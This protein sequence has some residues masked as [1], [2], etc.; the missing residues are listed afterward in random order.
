[1]GNPADIRVH[2][3][4]DVSLLASCTQCQQGNKVF[5]MVYKLDDPEN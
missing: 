1:M 5:F 3:P 2:I 4:G